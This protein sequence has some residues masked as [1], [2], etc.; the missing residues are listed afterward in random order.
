LRTAL[1]FPT[2]DGVAHRFGGSADDGTTIAGDD[3]G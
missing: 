3:S 1:F 2:R